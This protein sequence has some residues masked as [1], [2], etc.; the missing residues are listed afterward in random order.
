MHFYKIALLSFDYNITQKFV[1]MLV[2]ELH[3]SCQI[4]SSFYY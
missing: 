2:N 3:V 1:S 4:C